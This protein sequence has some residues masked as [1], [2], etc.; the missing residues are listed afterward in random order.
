MKIKGAHVVILVAVA[1]VGVLIYGGVRMAGESSEEPVSEEEFIEEIRQ[2]APVVPS[3]EAGLVPP[4]AKADEVPKIELEPSGDINMGTI[5]NDEKTTVKVKVHNKGKAPLKVIRIQNQCGC[6]AGKMEEKD[7]L[8]KPGE[9]SYLSITADPARLASGFE[10]RKKITLNTND[11]ALPSLPIQV[12]VKVDPEYELEPSRIAFGNVEKGA[13][14]EKTMLLRQLMDEPLEIRNITTSVRNNAVEA[15]YQQRPKEQWKDP[16]KAEY[17]IHVRLADNV[18]LGPFNGRLIIVT[19]LKRRGQ[20]PVT[21]MATVTSW[22]SISPARMLVL[23]EL[24]GDDKK[25]GCQAIVAAERPFEII[26]LEPTVEGLAAEVVPGESENSKIIK[27]TLEDNAKPKGRIEYLNFKIKSGEEVLE[28]VLEIRIIPSMMPGARRRP[29]YNRP[30]AVMP[31]RPP[32]P[33]TAGETE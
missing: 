10:S 8:I 6:T 11:P 13:A 22:Y 20:I 14:P 27:L 3:T 30:R 15:T 5:P 23:R 7:K 16:D 1:I 18:P 19:N 4:M 28:E 26:D 21:V 31:S 9:F 12:I 29:P 25:Q 17:N 24:P 33:E 2:I 32:A